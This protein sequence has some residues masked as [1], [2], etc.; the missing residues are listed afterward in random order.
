MPTI[1]QIQPVIKQTPPI[2]VIAPN[3]RIPVNERTYKLPENNTIP[4]IM[5][6]VA[7]ANNS[8]SPTSPISK[9]PLFLI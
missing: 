1:R 6:Y 3:L 5:N 7:I 9:P 8:N 4:P 2:G